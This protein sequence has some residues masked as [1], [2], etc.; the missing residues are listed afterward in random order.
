ME[1]TMTNFF[2]NLEE[3]INLKRLEKA[4]DTD[5]KNGFFANYVTALLFLKLQDLKGL[6]LINDHGHANLTKFSSHMSDLNFWARAMFHA[7]D[8]E[9]KSRIQP[10]DAADLI[11][12]AKKVSAT[13]IQKIMKVPL[14]APDAINWNEVIGA[15]LLLQYVFNVQSSYFHGILKTLHK[16]DTVNFNTKQ[17]AINDS[18][19]FMMQSDPTSKV[20]PHLRKLSNLIASRRFGT[21]A[22]KIIGFAKLNETADGGAVSTGGVA[23]TSNAIIDPRARA[24]N[25]QSGWGDTKQDLDKDL[26][27]LYRLKKLSPEKNTDKQ[28]GKYKIRDGKTIKKRARTF[29]TKKFKAPAFLKPKKI[30]KAPESTP[31]QTQGTENDN[32]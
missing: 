8:K 24:T 14:T 4:D 31:S 6:E 20:I 25:S 30:E 16:W 29:S 10:E 5:I 19:M 3:S 12:A 28:N 17:K 22:Q 9:V 11:K 21:A 13:R 26:G 23:S 18:L 7:G 2:A 1:V 32:A 15:I 27:G